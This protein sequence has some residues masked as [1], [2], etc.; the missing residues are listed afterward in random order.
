MARR[1]QGLFRDR[2]LQV[3][4]RCRVTGVDKSRYLIA[5][6][7]KPW[8]KSS[9]F[10][11]LSE[12]NGLML[13]PHVDYLFDN[14]YIS[15]TDNGDLLV[16]PECPAEVVRAWGISPT[17]NVGPFRAQQR[18]YLAYHREKYGFNN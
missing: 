3:E 9:T 18:P 1:G 12:N 16:S 6:H 10:E 13:A 4:P 7:I 15:F 11:R 17:M 2:V 8:S 14:G 5:S